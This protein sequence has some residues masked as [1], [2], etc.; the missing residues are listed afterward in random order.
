VFTPYF[1][2]LHVGGQMDILRCW[3]INF[4]PQKNG[5]KHESITPKIIQIIQKHQKII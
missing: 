3:L 4:V 5:K 2:I 1:Q